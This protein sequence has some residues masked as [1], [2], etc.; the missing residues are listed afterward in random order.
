MFFNYERPFG[1]LGC[2]LSMTFG[3]ASRIRAGDSIFPKLYPWHILPIHKNQSIV[4]KYDIHGLYGYK[5]GFIYLEPQLI[6]Q[7]GHTFV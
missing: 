3:G 4:G 2:R 1:L 6:P 7:D 5:L